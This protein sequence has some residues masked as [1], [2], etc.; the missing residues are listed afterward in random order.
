M[1]FAGRIMLKRTFF[2]FMFKYLSFPRYKLKLKHTIL[3]FILSNIIERWWGTCCCFTLWLFMKLRVQCFMM[4][5]F[6][7]SYIYIYIHIYIG[8]GERGDDMQQRA[9]AGVEPRPLR[10]GTSG[11]CE[12]Y[13][14]TSHHIVAMMLIN[15]CVMQKYILQAILVDCLQSNQYINISLNHS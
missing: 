8:R 15:S 5:S 3:V 10:W 14:I 6:S 4:L 1:S 11:M 9:Q 2:F 13:Q 12:L 7:R